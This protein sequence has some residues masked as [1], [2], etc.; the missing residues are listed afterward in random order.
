MRKVLAFAA[1]TAISA[2]SAPLDNAIRWAASP[3][4]MAWAKKNPKRIVKN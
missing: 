3:D 4:A 2:L 1:V